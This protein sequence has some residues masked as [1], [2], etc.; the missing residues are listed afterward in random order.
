MEKEK[1]EAQRQEASGLVWCPESQS[2]WPFTYFPLCVC[3]R[4]RVFVCKDG[5][6]IAPILVVCRVCNAIPQVRYKR[7]RERSPGSSCI[8]VCVCALVTAIS[9]PLY[10]HGVRAGPDARTNKRELICDIRTWQLNKR[11]LGERVSLPDSQSHT[12]HARTG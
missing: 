1:A 11:R 5:Y 10:H 9:N 2:L 12:L 6:L 4:G 8:Y 3:A 7:M